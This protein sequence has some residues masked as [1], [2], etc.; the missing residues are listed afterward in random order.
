MVKQVK[1]PTTVALVAAEVRVQSLARRRGLKDLVL[2][3]LRH[4]SQMWLRFSSWPKNFH[5]PWV[6]TL[7]K[8][9]TVL[10]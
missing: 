10:A 7:R 4:G 6:Q 8:K 1:N 9:K 5:M 3:Q 2:L